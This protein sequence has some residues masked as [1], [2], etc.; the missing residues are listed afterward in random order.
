MKMLTVAD[1]IT[2]HA[3]TKKKR[4]VRRVQRRSCRRASASSK[5]IAY[6]SD[7]DHDQHI[8]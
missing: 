1:L 5:M 7:V 4:Y 3:S 8:G 6:S 2:T